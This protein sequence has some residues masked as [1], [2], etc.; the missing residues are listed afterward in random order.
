MPSEAQPVW[1]E[2]ALRLPL[3]FERRSV[4]HLVVSELHLGLESQLARHGAF[5]KSRTDDL[6]TRLLRIADS[7]R[8]ERLVILGDVKHRIGQV[9]AQERG[10]VPAFFRRLEG[11]ERIDI[12]LG[13]HD[14]GLRAL[15]PRHA[16]PNVRLH[17]A[18]GFLLE[19]D[20]EAIACLHG[21]AW[22]HPRL[23]EAETFLVGHTHA[24]AA[25][26][27]EAGQATTEWAWLRASLNPH[28]VREKFGRESRANV[29]VFPPFNPLCGGV[30]I[31]REGLL[32]PFSKLVD[33]RRAELHLLDGRRLGPFSPPPPK[34]KKARHAMRTT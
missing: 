1:N 15:L 5:L 18:T 11:F 3:R 16:F 12:A 17:P 23:M 27:N 8:A 21:H 6:A 4:T 14:V 34:P 2:P 10:D 13:N 26:V 19:S 24:A 30:A 9:G 31:N 7:V 28:V 25:L 20:R 33:W 29:V 32:G 22:P